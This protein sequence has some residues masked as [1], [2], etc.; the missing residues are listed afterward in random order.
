MHVT[1]V[2]DSTSNAKGHA[3]M[4][5]IVKQDESGH[6]VLSTRGQLVHLPSC[7]QTDI[8]ISRYVLQVFGMGD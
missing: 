5:R 7:T 2:G 4:Q 8:H 1:A 3:A 6:E